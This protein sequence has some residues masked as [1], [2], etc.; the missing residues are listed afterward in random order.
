MSCGKCPTQVARLRVVSCAH[1]KLNTTL[2]KKGT[3][4][5]FPSRLGYVTVV[6]LVS[7]V[8]VLNVAQFRRL[9][10]SAFANVPE[11]ISAVSFFGLNINTPVYLPYLLSRFLRFGGHIVRASIQHIVQI[12]EGGVEVFANGKSGMQTA[13]ALIIC[14]G[15]GARTLGGVEDKNVYPVRGQTVLLDAPWVNEGRS[16]VI[17]SVSKTYIIPR[18]GGTVS[19]YSGPT[20]IMNQ[21]NASDIGCNW[22]CESC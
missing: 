3:P 14:A 9:E 13:D 6:N 11:A 22:W 18:Q 2:P 8:I 19:L 16:L 17:E 1:R 12:L 5:Y 7:W 21:G 10:P 4:I 20:L 15:L